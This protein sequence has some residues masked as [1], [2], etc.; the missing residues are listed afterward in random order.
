MTRNKVRVFVTILIVFIV[1]IIILN[2]D[3]IFK[4]ENKEPYQVSVICR[5][6][7]TESSTSIKHGINQ[8]ARDFNVDVSFITLMNENDSNEQISLLEREV[9]N[10]VDAVIITPAN[11]EHLTKPI[12]EAQKSVPIIAMQSTVNTKK[13]LPYISSDNFELGNALAKEIV[14]NGENKRIAILRNSMECSNIEK[15]HLGILQGLN[16]THNMIEYWD[17]PSDPQD[18]YQTAK[19]RLSTSS[20]DTLIALDGAVLEAA[21]KAEKDLINEGKRQVMIYGIGRT[22]SVVSLLEEN[23]INSIGVENEYNMGYLSIQTAVKT[24][25]KKTDAR[26]ISVNFAIVTPEN[27]YDPENQRLLF[28]FVK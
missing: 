9:K 6:I 27:M 14:K 17:I 25:N 20:A 1:S 22:N 16:N 7:S 12:E 11:S 13:V 26:N 18:A 8:A 23:I 21:A 4:K 24:I 19:R 3:Q 5:S 15:R 10:G 2:K 28:P